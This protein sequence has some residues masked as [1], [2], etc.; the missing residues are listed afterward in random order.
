MIDERRAS[1]LV[2]DDFYYSIAGKVTLSGVYI[3]DIVIPAVDTP[4]SQIVFY[5]SIETPKERPFKIVTIKI[6]FPGLE[7]KITPIPVFPR[8]YPSDPNR[9]KITIKQPI[10]I[11]Q[12][13]LNPGKVQ[14]TVIH[15]DFE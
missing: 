3:Q 2:S 7:P 15:E 13:L 14:A 12:I 9:T 10:L 11:Q 1:I 5:F 8:V 6:E 4:I